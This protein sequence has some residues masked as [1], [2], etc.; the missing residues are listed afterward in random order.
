M[1]RRAVRL[2]IVSRDRQD[3]ERDRYEV[4]AGLERGER[5][6]V[7]DA[8]AILADGMSVRLKG[9]VFEESGPEMESSPVT[10]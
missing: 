4:L 8:T 9:D 10:P 3:P 7:G 1:R 5:V 6:V 2:G